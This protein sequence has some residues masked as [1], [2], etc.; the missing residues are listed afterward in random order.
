MFGLR[1]SGAGALCLG[2]L[3]L[4]GCRRET[5]KLFELLPPE[6]TGIAFANRLPEDTSFN[7]LNYPY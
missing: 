4:V 1:R 3:A 6:A 7:I 5:P 2:A